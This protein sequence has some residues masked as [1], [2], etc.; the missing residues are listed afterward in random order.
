[1]PIY[2]TH[3]GAII[4]A[5]IARR[6]RDIAAGI[7]LDGYPLFTTLE[8]D[9]HHRFY[10]PDFTPDWDGSHVMRLW[11]RV[12]DQ[13]SFFPWYLPGDATR[14][15]RDELKA[16]TLVTIACETPAEVTQ[17]GSSS[18]PTAR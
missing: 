3:T 10:L 1:M 15:V 6:H 12:R 7:V 4:A 5:E 11:A 2:G 13:Y 8:R 16:G 14:L 18:A 9:L 17:M